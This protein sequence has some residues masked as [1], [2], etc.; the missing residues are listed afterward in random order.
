M[1]VKISEDNE[2]IYTQIGTATWK[3]SSDRMER[4]NDTL[5]G[6]NN[7]GFSASHYDLSGGKKLISYRGTDFDFSSLEGIKEFALD[8]S[9]GWAQSFGLVSPEEL[10]IGP[11]DGL[12]N[13]QPYYA[14]KFFELVTGAKIILSEEEKEALIAAG[15]RVAQLETQLETATQE[16]NA[17][18]PQLEIARHE[19]DSS[20]TVFDDAAAEANA[21]I[22]GEIDTPQEFALQA[23]VGNSQTD[24]NAKQS[25]VD[26]FEDR[27]SNAEAD[28]TDIEQQ[29]AGAKQ[30]LADKQP[31]KS[32]VDVQLTGHSLGGALAGYVAA[33]DGEKAVIFNE[34]AFLAMSF[35]T[36]LGMFIET[37]VSNGYSALITALRQIADGEP[38][39]VEGYYFTEFE[40]PDLSKLKSFRMDGEIAG[41]VRETG[42]FWAS[43]SAVVSELIGG[44]VTK[45]L[46]KVTGSLEVP[47]PVSVSTIKTLAAAIFQE[48][49]SSELAS[50]TIDPHAN[51]SVLD[52][53]ALHSQALM[54]V[55][56]FGKY[57][58]YTDWQDIGE[59]LFNALN[60]TQVGEAAGASRY[61]G[62]AGAAEKMVIGLSYS[63]LEGTDGLVF[64]NTGALSLFNDA[65]ELGN[66]IDQQGVNPFFETFSYEADDDG[67]LIYN[68]DYAI[69]DHLAQITV[70]YA[71]AL[72]LN[73]VEKAKAAEDVEF[74]ADHSATDGVLTINLD[75]DVL[76][77]DLSSVL[78]LDVLKS[79][80]MPI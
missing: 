11:G 9:T 3:E 12:V 44:R 65:N 78:W 30:D 73:K 22:V 47:L 13:F 76:A 55:H 52:S 63:T 64:G 79:S 66:A 40:L 41:F 14:V 32:P 16:K 54:V 59:E 25:V 39:N 31:K 23:A 17:L 19:R 42:S 50:E 4:D 10:D 48:K 20:Q 7:I 75:Q 46:E 49:F 71:G 62:Y 72:A 53:S 5:S 18:L 2:E 56:L 8:V 45:L 60:N 80:G 51:T 27:Y 58:G 36:K 38:V 33:F 35:Y 21:G 69:K 34:I 1:K 57:K 61:T 68:T 70:Q 77:L 24:L 26:D 28:E 67:G 6:S 43:L 37:N 15:N 74:T 29:L